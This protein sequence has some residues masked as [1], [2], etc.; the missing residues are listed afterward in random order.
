MA[1]YDSGLSDKEIKS[2]VDMAK[3]Y[4]NKR[5]KS[6]V[7]E[8]QDYNQSFA[9]SNAGSEAEAIEM[10]IEWLKTIPESFVKSWVKT[11]D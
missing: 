1:K 8:F 9:T 2:L 3:V 4:L 10:A 6:Y 11:E 5:D 7:V